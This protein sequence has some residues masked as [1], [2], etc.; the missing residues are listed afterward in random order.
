MQPKG[1][2]HATYSAG[3]DSESDLLV[4]ESL[5]NSYFHATSMLLIMLEV[6]V[7]ATHWCTSHSLQPKGYFHAAYSAGSD[8]ESDPLSLSMQPNGYFYATYHA[9]SVSE[10]D[11]LVHKSHSLQPK[12]YFNAT[13]SAGS[14]SESQSSVDESLGMQPNSYY[15]IML[16]VVEA[17]HSYTRVTACSYFHANVLHICNVWTIRTYSLQTL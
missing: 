4:D 14:D 7:K 6:S 13:Y 3:S 2:F 15:L 10:S 12:G 1:Y 9:R 8:G 16:E 11:S 17:T 5:P